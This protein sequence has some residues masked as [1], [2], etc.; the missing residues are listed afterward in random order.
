MIDEN[1]TS[2]HRMTADSQELERLIDEIK[3]FLAASARGERESDMQHLLDLLRR[4]EEADGEEIQ[5]EADGRSLA[6]RPLSCGG[7]NGQRNKPPARNG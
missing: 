3:G 4:L 6:E 5:S 2:F 1:P 7:L